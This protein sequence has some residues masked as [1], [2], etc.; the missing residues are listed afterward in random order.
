MELKRKSQGTETINDF[1]I[2]QLL[3]GST[4]DKVALE[5][6]KKSLMLCLLLIRN[7]L[8]LLK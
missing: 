2:V 4:M 6:T 5:R 8:H 7:A 3:A 1:P